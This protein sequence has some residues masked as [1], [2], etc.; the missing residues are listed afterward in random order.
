M[1]DG[2]GSNL[3][4]VSSPST[5]GGRRKV[6]IGDGGSPFA[7]D[8][9][10]STAETSPSE[11][12]AC[13]GSPTSASTANA[14]PS[15][16]SLARDSRHSLSDLCPTTPLSVQSGP[17]SSPASATYSRSSSSSTG[18][19]RGIDHTALLLGLRD[20]FR[21]E[22]DEGGSEDEREWNAAFSPSASADALDGGRIQDRTSE[23]EG[24]NVCDGKS[25]E[26]ERV[27]MTA[28]L[29]LDIDGATP[30]SGMGVSVCPSRNLSVSTLDLFDDASRPR[31]R[32]GGRRAMPTDPP[33]PPRECDERRQLSPRPAAFQPSSAPVLPSF[34]SPSFGSPKTGQFDIGSPP[35]LGPFK[36]TSP[37]G[38]ELFEIC[39]N[40]PGHELFE[41]GSPLGDAD[42][43]GGSPR[44]GGLHSSPKLGR[45]RGAALPTIYSPQE[46]QDEQEE[47]EMAQ[48]RQQRSISS[49]SR[50][51]PA[52]LLKRR[53]TL[54]SRSHS[55]SSAAKARVLGLR[56]KASRKF[57][58]R[59]SSGHVSAPAS[60]QGS[61]DDVV[62]PALSS[63]LT[64]ND[65]WSFDSG[66]EIP[67]ARPFD[68]SFEDMTTVS[69]ISFAS[70]SRSGKFVN[71]SFG[72][73]ASNPAGNSSRRRLA[74]AISSRTTRARDRTVSA[75][76]TAAGPAV[77]TGNPHRRAI[78]RAVR[79]QMT[80]NGCLSPTGDELDSAPSGE[81]GETRSTGV[82]SSRARPGLAKRISSLT[83]SRRLGSGSKDDAAGRKDDRT[84]CSA[85]GGGERPFSPRRTRP[86]SLDDFASVIASIGSPYDSFT[87]AAG[88]QHGNPGV[89][90]VLSNLSSQNGFS[91][92]GSVS[93][94]EGA[95]GGG[96]VV[97]SAI[98]SAGFLI[99]PTPSAE[100]LSPGCGG[101]LGAGEGDP[102]V[103]FLSPL[104][105][106]DMFDLDYGLPELLTG[107]SATERRLVMEAYP[108]TR[109]FLRRRKL[110][111]GGGG[112]E[113][114]L[115]ASVS[116]EKEGKESKRAVRLRLAPRISRS[117]NRVGLTGKD[118]TGRGVSMFRR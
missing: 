107:A 7:D 37:P 66:L 90:S 87:A 47:S 31:R 59:R 25:P 96:T 79:V 86:G 62:G 20:E 117:M 81:L 92:G 104:S 49:S 36:V 52:P 41:V 14:S 113:V 88:S 98:D 68:S 26:D 42:F 77:A 40:P 82:L 32:E 97:I 9:T 35:V 112:L 55:A 28:S 65:A 50:Q 70:S 1:R 102:G 99:T 6:A 29:Q 45:T 43:E 103:P 69:Q 10:A 64:K 27:T 118:K 89:S 48:R 67:S 95:A 84:L 33:S 18:G 8:L 93:E 73:S 109:S 63:S 80:E 51:R 19:A 30:E 21:R 2:P 57:T 100:M 108:E 91:A 114:P 54:A 17:G 24:S 60:R 85:D 38:L 58:S 94:R 72:R 5:P 16:P 13:G 12:T 15:D 75:L 115:T 44:P 74:T 111:G 11:S 56:E 76:L 78:D 106:G 71:R 61:A 53:P 116:G 110:G 105:N 101:P 34:G 83:S 46:L 3:Y 22:N 39:G 23:E 4:K